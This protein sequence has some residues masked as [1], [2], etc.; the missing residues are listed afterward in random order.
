LPSVSEEYRSTVTSLPPVPKLGFT[1]I[2]LVP[3]LTSTAPPFLIGSEKVMVK[4]LGPVTVIF[5]ATGS[6]ASNALKLT[7]VFSISTPAADLTPDITA[8]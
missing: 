1:P 8:L 5:S 4:F 6:V 2:T 3:D 7:S